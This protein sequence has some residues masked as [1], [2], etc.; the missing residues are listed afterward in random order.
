VTATYTDNNL[1]LETKG[2]R[3]TL[4]ALSDREFRNTRFGFFFEFD[5]EGQQLVIHD[6]AVTYWL[7]KQK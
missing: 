4:E 5:N 1:A 6:A 3:F 7:H 2:Q